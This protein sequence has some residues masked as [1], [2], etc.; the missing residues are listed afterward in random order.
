MN[1]SRWLPDW[2]RRRSP[3]SPSF[4]GS[5]P[6][7]AKW[8]LAASRLIFVFTVLAIAAMLA[9]AAIGYSLA[10]QNDERLTAEQHT[11]LRNAVAEFGSPIDPS[12]KIEPRLVRIAE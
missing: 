6:H 3:V 8:I 5:V 10:R 2:L 7:P 1:F 11:A 9:S 4:L 12:G